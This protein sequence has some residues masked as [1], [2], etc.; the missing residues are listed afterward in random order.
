MCPDTPDDG[1]GHALRDAHGDI[2]RCDHCP[3]NSLD[4]AIQNSAAGFLLTRVSEIDCALRFHLGDQLPVLNM[5][6]FN[7]LRIVRE[8]RD[9][10]EREQM[11]ATPTS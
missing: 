7:A 3:L 6:E 2:M 10:W 9:K 8:E 5:E 11:P 1:E 4:A